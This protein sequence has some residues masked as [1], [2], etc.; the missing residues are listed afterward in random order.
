MSERLR[1]SARR[2][3]RSC[4]RNFGCARCGKYLAYAVFVADKAAFVLAFL[5]FSVY[6]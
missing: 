2:G 4:V 3:E 6:Y 5:I 1:L